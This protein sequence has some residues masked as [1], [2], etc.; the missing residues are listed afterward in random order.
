[1][2]NFIKKLILPITLII[3]SVFVPKSI[4]AQAAEVS[5]SNWADFKTAFEDQTTTKITLTN[6]ITYTGVATNLKYRTTDIVIDGSKAGT[7]PEDFKNYKLD[8]ANTS[9]MI[10]KPTNSGTATMNIQNITLANNGT[11]G[12]DVARGGI[13]E[14]YNAYSAS[15]NN[16]Y[17]QYWTF[18]MKNVYVPDVSSTSGS[19]R[20]FRTP[21]AQINVSGKNKIYTRAENFYTGGVNFA[22][23]TEYYGEITQNNYSI[24]WFNSQVGAS[25]TGTGDFIVGDGA[26]VKLRNV[27][28]TNNT[29]Y[30]AIYMYYRSI[31]IGENAQFT[32]SVPGA[33]VQFSGNG[34]TFNA[35]KG[36]IVTLTS[37]ASYPSIQDNVTN[38]VGSGANSSTPLMDWSG[39][40]A[41]NMKMLF[42]PGSNLYV[43]G[44]T[45]GVGDALIDLGSLAA[46]KNNSIILDNPAN[47]DIR[48]NASNTNRDAVQVNNTGSNNSFT[49]KNSNM[50]FWKLGSSF[51]STA[52]FDYTDVEELTITDGHKVTS[53]NSEL[54]AS[55][56][57]NSTTARSNIARISGLNVPPTINW[58]YT[59]T[60]AD[61]QLT[62]LARVK[63]GDVPDDTGL[64]ENGDLHYTELFASKGLPVE[65]TNPKTGNKAT[66]L[67]DNSGYVSTTLTDFLD[68]GMKFSAIATRGN[69]VS[70]PSLSEPV[71]NITPPKPVKVNTGK[72]YESDSKISGS[73]AEVGSKVYLQ[74]NGGAMTEVATV[75]ESGNFSYTL[76]NKFNVGDKVQVYLRDTAGLAPTN[77]KVKAPTTNDKDGNINPSKD[78]VYSDATFP[79]ASSYVVEK[80]RISKATATKKVSL[81]DG[82]SDSP[83]SI[84]D[85]VTYTIS[86]SN[87]EEDGSNIEWNDVYLEDVLDAGLIYE[88]SN[89]NVTVDGVKISDAS[90]DETSRK[91]KVPLGKIMPKKASG[92]NVKNITFD[93]KVSS[94]VAGKTISNIATVSGKD[95]SNNDF[96]IKSNQADISSVKNNTI[97]VN[98]T[99]L[100]GA[101]LEEP[102]V[103]Q[104]AIG[105][106]QDLDANKDVQSTIEKIVNKNYKLIT[107]PSNT[108]VIIT[109]NG[110]KVD[111]VFDGILR[112]VSAPKTIDFGTLQLADKVQTVHPQSID[113]DLVIS[114][115]RLA[116]N[117]GWSLSA[118]VTKPLTNSG[119]KTIPN[120]LSYNTGKSSIL[121]SD[122]DAIIES[123]TSKGNVDISSDWGNTDK[124]K[125]LKLSYNPAEMSSGN[126]L[127]TYTGE[128][129]WTISEVP[130]F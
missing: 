103:I 108:K 11:V 31:Q 115:T 63:L 51:S 125:G 71:F 19:G 27:R 106:T 55:L 123:N 20:L 128:V 107:P 17:G 74:V 44:R 60:D 57:S 112:I 25:D 49:V 18:N 110:D 3:F 87:D 9:L 69:L 29:G 75:D 43:I 35:K 1:M 117:N 36:S 7:K 22:D 40:S 92:E 102:I 121:L 96:T 67:T 68:P 61:K 47:F 101:K 89:A 94:E 78:L 39:S 86:V 12:A 2:L 77:L 16:Q 5:V 122:S 127:G 64:D 4:T 33:A 111:Y 21:R 104:G 32:A 46:K 95:I 53:S 130:K 45:T 66:L 38:F 98:F 100:N 30:P 28:N 113:D 81:K 26:N 83:I 62:N 73:G 59:I 76:P 56:N 79:A 13:I 116:Q 37:L 99:D 58:Q 80:G 10:G 85:T 84:G 90:Y 120:A 124:S 114:D 119:G 109:G 65:I 14:T 105:S 129:T 97:T 6:D 118:K 23:G 15:N 24:I 42:E 52:D 48:N 91:L 41:R 70:E 54:A 72:I 126:V 8:L 88:P 93:A 82:K 34:Q 50:S